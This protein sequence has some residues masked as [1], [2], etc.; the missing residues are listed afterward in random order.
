M[1]ISDDD[2]DLALGKR[3][4]A[5]DAPAPAAAS[6]PVPG[7]GIAD[8]DPD[9][10]LGKRAGADPDFS[11]PDP[12]AEAA[13]LRAL[14]P[15]HAAAANAWNAY[16]EG[17]WSGVETLARNALQPAPNTAY[18]ELP[19]D[20]LATDAAT[21][22]PRFAM[23]N[24]IRSGLLDLVTP[25]PLSQGG[26]LVNF[27][28][29]EKGNVTPALSPASNLLLTAY[30]GSRFNTGIEGVLG[31]GGVKGFVNRGYP[32]SDIQ[33]GPFDLPARG[34]PDI[35]L[36]S[37]NALTISPDTIAARSAAR[38]LPLAPDERPSG[39]APSSP[40][41]I[42]TGSEWRPGPLPGTSTRDAPAATG[43]MT[44][45]GIKATVAAP[46]YRVAE[47]ANGTITVPAVNTALDKASAFLERDP[48]VDVAAGNDT[49]A[50][51]RTKLDAFR[52]DP[53][54]ARSFDG[55][56]KMLTQT[57]TSEYRTNGATETAKVLQDMQHSLRDSFLNASAS[58]VNGGAAGFSALNNARQAWAAASRMEDLEQIKARAE[59]TKNPA[60]SYQ[61]Q[62]NNLINNARRTRGYTSEELAALDKARDRGYVDEAIQTFGQRLIPHI[63]GAIGASAGGGLGA[64]L[65]GGPL[66]ATLGGA[67]GFGVGETLGSVGS[68]A[69]RNWATARAGRPVQNALELLS[70]RAPPPPGPLQP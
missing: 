53:L 52:D 29:D 23:P 20:W 63:T 13:R 36:P 15:V 58:D 45:E 22:A 57:I 32:G 55:L 38:N 35:T 70:Q 48:K 49:I 28:V 50:Q 43:P 24:L 56:D 54:S 18:G 65:G 8:D 1:P 67:A 17:G 39:A 64:L 37:P 59:G 19:W 21:G 4:G 66:G 5:S 7:K 26:G 9:L 3:V 69:M 68:T 34:L 44:S 47:Q 51:W 2:P 16:Q 41:G 12:A 61:T 6:A 40:V 42:T 30:G 62:I 31:P 27:S 33:I 11:I 14:N 60:T 10:A 46:W 25:T